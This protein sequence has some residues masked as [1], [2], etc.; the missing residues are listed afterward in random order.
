M[1]RLLVFV[2][3][4][5]F[6]A[7]SF[8]CE[9]EKTADKTGDKTD[10]T[11]KAKTDA[12][13]V[14]KTVKEAPIKVK[15]PVKKVEVKMVPLDLT[16]A[17][18]KA[19]IDAPA[20]AV[21]ADSFGTIE[22]KVGDGTP[23]FVQIDTEAAKMADVKKSVETNDMQ[24]LKKMLMDTPEVIMYN[25]EFMGKVSFWFD[26]NVKVGD[27]TV[28]C[29]SGRGAPSFDEAQINTMLNACK[30]LKNL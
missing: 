25:T 22:V 4:A 27:K 14:A 23:F 16:A 6:L 20:G 30:T 17:G 2:V 1:K 19:T 29:Y 15:E 24:K 21:A 11:V 26:S 18:L 5:M 8:G 9:A 28:H 10:K 3:L 7:G 12:K 13:T